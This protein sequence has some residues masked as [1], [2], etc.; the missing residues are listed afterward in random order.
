MKIFITAD[1]SEEGIKRL[2][3]AGHDVNYC[4]WGA[5]H[6]ICTEEQ[7]TEKLQG[8]TSFLSGMNQFRKKY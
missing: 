1:F 4:C 3:D 5:T 6:E 2:T 8:L 7:L